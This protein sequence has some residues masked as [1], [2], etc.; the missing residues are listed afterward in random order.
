[1]VAKDMSADLILLTET[2][3]NSSSNTAILNID[4][5]S[6]QHDI[7]RDREDTTGG[8]GGGLLVYAKE[9]VN[10]T[11]EE[12]KMDFNQAVSF[13]V[14]EGRDKHNLCLVYRPPGGDAENLESLAREIRAANETT[15][16]I[17]DFN[18][19]GVDWEG[20]GVRGRGEEVLQAAEEGSFKQLVTFSTHTKGNI[21]DLVLT[22]APDKVASVS[23]E[24]R[25]G[26]SDHSVIMIE[27]S[28]KVERREEEKEVRNWNRANWQE[29]RDGL[30]RTVWP[31]S[32]DDTSTEEAWKMLR[33]KLDELIEENV[34]KSKLRSRHN[35]W[36]NRHILR[37]IRMKRRLWRKAKTG[38]QEDKE[39]Y[40]AAER[41]VANMIRNAKRAEERKLAKEK[42]K[43]SKPFFAYVKKRT[44]AR[45]PVG[46]LKKDDGTNVTDPEEMAEI[47]NEFFSSVY[48]REDV[49]GMPAVPP[50]RIRKKLRRTWITTEKVKKKICNLRNNS[51]PGP[52][53]ISPKILKNLKDQIAPVLAMVYR[54]SLARSEVP[55][56][57]RQANICPIYKKGSKAKAGNYRPVS[58]TSVCC[59]MIESILR[60]D[61]VE[62]LQQNRLITSSQ[63][64]FVNRKSCTTNLLEFLEKMTKTVDE[65][66]KA[67][68][69]YLDFAK[70]FDK[71]PHQRLLKKIK[72]A[73]IEGQ[74]LEW[75]RAWLKER[76]SRVVVN[77][78]KSSWRE[79]LSG[80][81][82]GS[83]L[84]PILFVIYINDLEKE[85][86]QN[87][88]VVLFADDTKVSQVLKDN[89]S[90]DEFQDT[91]NKLF[92]WSQRWCMPFNVEKCHI[93][94]VGRANPKKKYE[95]NGQP[96][97]ESLVERDVGVMITN[98][99][100][101]SQHC[102]KAA[103]TATAVLNQ[104]LRAF[105]YRDRKTFVQLYLQYVRPHLEFASPAWSPWNQGD[106]DCLEKVQQRAVT[107]V[108]GLT[109][110]TY[111]ERLTE[112]GL[113]SLEDRRTEADMI[114]TFKILAG[115]D[116]VEREKWFRIVENG[117][118][119]R[120]NNGG[121]TLQQQRSRLDLRR[122]FFSQRVVRTWN[123]L[124]PETRGSTSVKAFKCAIRRA[125]NQAAPAMGS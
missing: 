25:I 123:S 105:H 70:A 99:L 14:G 62:H 50:A 24:G 77:G 27:I 75:I 76:K 60:D 104:I 88:Q 69:L 20:G 48:T 31:T 2:W 44:K 45:D 13:A 98:D 11:E 115:I 57:W 110:R 12:K 116:D 122:N 53:G 58:L 43:N 78:K 5:Y 89:A 91:M 29:M 54:K 73:G 94:H 67:D 34:P 111:A 63:H 28:L 15:T 81:P 4:G 117:R 79:V 49:T 23:E 41:K 42:T 86:K 46:P 124:A 114:Q 17:G 52:D 56:E 61:I 92:E 87:Q 37:E 19:P 51:A 106:I 1:M 107:A 16:F 65:G 22:N 100:K 119:T 59:K 125:T 108:S 66:G 85:V 7:R 102:A 6:I 93:V 36:M 10:I 64:G 109:G 74:T 68:V 113:S 82:Q 8:V 84:G 26:K 39:A 55:E 97:T 71:V 80:V 32:E 90:G 9:G 21:L 121:I 118:T 18:L 47:L 120:T 30:E 38:G 35:G 72:A 3:L 103:R 33:T 101:P 83:V 95:M 96:L 40:K 112:L